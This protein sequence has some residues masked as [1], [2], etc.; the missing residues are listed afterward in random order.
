M[1]GLMPDP[2]ATPAA[3]PPSSFRGPGVAFLL[4]QVG[5]RA[6]EEFSSA[7]SELEL[8]P[9]LAGIMRLLS[10]DPAVTQQQLAQKL[11]TAPSRVVA[12]LDDLE[13]RGW[14]TRTRD[15][16]DRRANIIHLTPAGR[17]SF[18]AIA[19]VGR[20]HE[21]R[22]TQPLTDDEAATLREL[23]T[24]VAA[25]LDLTEGVHPG[26]RSAAGRPDPESDTR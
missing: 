19:T 18:A 12:Y 4:A 26:Y 7:L 23:L 1:L 10:V 22:V 15:A 25:G 3:G 20:R 17:Q 11:R 8:S 21:E 24:R 13:A 2:R 14:I 16:G 9:G 5:A 6:A